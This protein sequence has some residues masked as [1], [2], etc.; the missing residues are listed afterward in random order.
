MMEPYVWQIG[1]GALLV[2]LL[3]GV[4]LII[5]SRRLDKRFG[6]DPR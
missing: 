5:E 6:K 3:S 2:G 4:P 1:L